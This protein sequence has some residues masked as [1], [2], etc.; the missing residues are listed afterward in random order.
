MGIK[1]MIKGILPC[2]IYWPHWI[3]RI[4]AM[5]KYSICH[6]YKFDINNPKTFTEKIFWYMTEYDCS[7]ISKISDKVLFKSYIQSKLGDGMTVKMYGA[8]DNVDGLLK[9]WDE[10]PNRV[11]LKSNLQGDDKCIKII[12]DKSIIDVNSLKKELQTWLEPKNTLLDKYDCRMYNSKPQ[13]LAE[14]YIENKTGQL[15][16]Y[17]FFCFHGEPYCVYADYDHTITFYDMD[18]K[19]MDVTYSKY[20][21][22]EVPKPIHFEEM[23]QY[24][25]ILSKDFPFVRVDMYDL[26]DRVYMGEMTF[27]PGASFQK[28]DPESFNELLGSKLHLPQ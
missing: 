25:R 14:E 24:A 22:G 4:M 13:I 8:W 3:F 15:F 12:L 23:K 16:D 26:Q 21:I 27:N 1:E 6:G 28:Y 5:R 20:K 19:K 2:K 18:W 9:N 17:K 7:E 11:V 10:L